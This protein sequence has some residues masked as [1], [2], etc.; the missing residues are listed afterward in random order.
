M[1]SCSLN[2]KILICL[3]IFLAV[4]G[5]SCKKKDAD[6]GA[7]IAVTIDGIDIAQS[8]IDRIVKSQLQ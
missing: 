5:L 6:S 1:R 4:S 8:E 2:L 3:A 7:N